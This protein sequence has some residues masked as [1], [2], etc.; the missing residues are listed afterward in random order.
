MYTHYDWCYSNNND[1]EY[2]SERYSYF[3]ILS[4]KKLSLSEQRYLTLCAQR[5]HRHEI[6]RKQKRKIFRKLQYYY[7]IKNQKNRKFLNNYKNEEHDT[8]IAPEIFSLSKDPINVI[9]FFNKA[10]E[11]LNRGR[12]VFF[13]LSK[14]TE[15]G[16]ETLTYFCAL[17]SDKHYTRHTAFRG[18]LP[19]DKSLKQMFRKAGFYSFVKPDRVLEDDYDNDI[20]G[21][22]IHRVT[23]EKVETDLAKAI[24][25][26]AMQ[27]TLPKSEVKRQYIYRILIECMANT[28]NHANFGIHDRIYNWWLLAYKEPVTN[29]TKF[30]FLDL[31]VG[32]FGSLENKYKF[33]I[34][35]VYL[36][37]LFSPGQNKKTLIQIFSGDKKT[38]TTDLRGRGEGLN[39]IHSL[40]TDDSKIRN[41]L[42]ISNDV[43]ARIGYNQTDSVET[44]KEKFNGTMYYWELVPPN[45]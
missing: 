19:H 38:S 6:K 34:L 8:C 33:G 26:S 35:P 12:P 7:R 28:H 11:S 44:I 3:N 15:M 39:Y 14:V 20:C 24:C 23:R 25:D 5:K 31:G 9:S 29:I 32:I 13:D 37:K 1:L 21:K 4:M 41:F 10:K 2:F 42:M 27:H 16:P 36:Q 18:N 45:E 43:V 22:L 40:A 30:C 17:I